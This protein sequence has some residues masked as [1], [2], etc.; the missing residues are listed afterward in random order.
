[1]GG[2]ARALGS[3]QTHRRRT[4]RPAEPATDRT[5]ARVWVSDAEG[6]SDKAGEAEAAAEARTSR[7]RVARRPPGQARRGKSCMLPGRLLVARGLHWVPM[8]PVRRRGGSAAHSTPCMHSAPPT[9][10]LAAMRQKGAD[11][12]R[13]GAGDEEAVP[14]WP[15]A[16]PDRRSACASASPL[17]GARA[18]AQ[19]VHAARVPHS[20]LGEG[21]GWR[22]REREGE[23]G[24]RFAVWRSAS[25]LAQRFELSRFAH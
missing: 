2:E 10:V 15:G 24:E 22:Q 20:T 13:A 21:W 9:R 11:H 17:T 14:A 12:E 5:W 8:A 23:R 7:G 4:Y 19:A 3:P 16:E 1:M 6:G 25:F 18:S